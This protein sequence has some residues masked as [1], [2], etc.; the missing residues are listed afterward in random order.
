[1]VPN[2]KWEN[3]EVLGP[4]IIKPANAAMV[5]DEM[6][7]Q[8]IGRLKVFVAALASDSAAEIAQKFSG[9]LKD[10]YLNDFDHGPRH[11]AD[12]LEKAVVLAK[13]INKSGEID[14]DVLIAAIAIHDIF[15]YEDIDHGPKAIAFAHDF[16]KGRMTEEQIS[17]V[18]EAIRLHD[19]R[20]EEGRKQREQAGIESQ[21]LFDVDQWEAFGYKG[22]YRFIVVYFGRGETLESIKQKV[23]GNAYNRWKWLTFLQTEKMAEGDYKILDD[24]FNRFNRIQTT[25]GAAQ[26]AQL[27]I[28]NSKDHP[29]TIAQKA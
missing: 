12:L 11:A 3:E 27:I 10:R 17:K 14:W 24:F 23:P 2:V 5:A 29:V 6:A 13:A 9:Q 4:D 28:N 19:V 16:L 21:I 26:A 1:M 20:N 22:V 8:L 7:T 25:N 18:E 15:A